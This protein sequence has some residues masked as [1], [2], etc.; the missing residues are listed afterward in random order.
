M[1]QLPRQ[2]EPLFVKNFLKVKI[3]YASNKGLFFY[4]PEFFMPITYY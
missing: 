3:V 4:S 1:T 2:R